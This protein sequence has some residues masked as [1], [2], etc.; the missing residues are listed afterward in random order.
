[1]LPMQDGPENPWIN[2]GI[3]VLRLGLP[4]GFAVVM[5]N[6]VFGITLTQAK[7]PCV[8]LHPAILCIPHVVSDL[9]VPRQQQTCIR[10][11]LNTDLHHR[12]PSTFIVPACP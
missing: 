9:F 11:T 5:M 12:I 7:D 4:L 3:S 10:M 8:Y 2:I 6:I 1:M